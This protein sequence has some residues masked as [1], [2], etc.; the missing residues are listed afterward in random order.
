M[1]FKK[2]ALIRNREAIEAKKKDFE[3]WRKEEQK[4]KKE[5]KMKKMKENDRK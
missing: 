3:Q 4:E 2:R 5:K 1:F